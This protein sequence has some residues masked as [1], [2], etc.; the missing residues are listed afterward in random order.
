M[1]RPVSEVRRLASSRSLPSERA[2]RIRSLPAWASVSAN[3]APMPLEAPVI[4]A[5]F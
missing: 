4:S 5:V 1:L 3:A 2:T